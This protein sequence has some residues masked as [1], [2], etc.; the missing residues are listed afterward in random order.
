MTAPAGRLTPITLHERLHIT[1]H[2]QSY[3]TPHDIVPHGRLETRCRNRPS[4]A[5]FPARCSP[6]WWGKTNTDARTPLATL[7][8]HTARYARCTAPLSRGV[9]LAISNRRCACQRLHCPCVHLSPA[10]STESCVC[11]HRAGGLKTH[12]YVGAC[13]W[14]LR[15][16]RQEGCRCVYLAYINAQL[17]AV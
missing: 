4:R 9:T 10:A 1:P 8:A 3:I 6:P 2:E 5:L 11:L 15:R 14:A 7:A 12:R 13:T 17:R 16:C